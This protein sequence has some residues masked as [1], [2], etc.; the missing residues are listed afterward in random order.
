MAIVTTDDKHYKAIADT[1]RDF[2]D[3]TAHPK[4]EEMASGVQSACITMYNS[5]LSDGYNSGYEAGKAEGG[6]DYDEGYEAGKQAEY[7]RFWDAFQRNGNMT[8][9]LGVFYGY[10]WTADTFKPKYDIRGTRFQNAFSMSTN[11]EGSLID[12]LDKC[13]VVIDTSQATNV[14]AMFY[15]ATRLT[16]IPHIDMSSINTSVG[17]LF[18]TCAKLVRIEKITYTENSACYNTG[19]FQGCNALTDVEFAGVI[20]GNMNLSWSPL[21]N[22]ATVQSLIDHLKD[23]TGATAQTIT[24][25]AT[26]GGKLTDA[27][28][29]TITAKNWQLVY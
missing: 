11:L 27:Q 4:P 29:A 16:E 1:I 20:A 9:Y 25:H 17:N 2:G 18:H 13:G 24:F 3:R 23:L 28:K 22:E 8:D 10:G 5:G 26:V 19:S 15:Y 12:M 7:D 6:G 21:L 14:S